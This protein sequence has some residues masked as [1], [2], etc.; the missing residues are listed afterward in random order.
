[1]QNSIKSSNIIK[2]DFTEDINLYELNYRET[3]QPN[4]SEYN[5]AL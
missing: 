1:M 3:I 2:H 4:E 5:E